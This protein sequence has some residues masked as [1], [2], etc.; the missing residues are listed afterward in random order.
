VKKGLRALDKV[1]KYDV[2]E[3]ENVAEKYESKAEKCIRKFKVSVKKYGRG[4]AGKSAKVKYG[5]DH[6]VKLMPAAGARIVRVTVDGRSV[7]LK[8]SYTFRKVRKK[9]EVVVVFSE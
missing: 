3:L 7:K 9:H 8:N 1:E 5:A 4:K 6:K 2:P